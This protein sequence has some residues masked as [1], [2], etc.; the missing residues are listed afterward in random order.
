MGEL[1]GI[2]AAIA[3]VW[4]TLAKFDAMKPVP[5][6]TGIL[7]TKVAFSGVAFVRRAHLTLR[8]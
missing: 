5:S 1:R 2:Q 4:R 3:F 7:A 8:K 6:V